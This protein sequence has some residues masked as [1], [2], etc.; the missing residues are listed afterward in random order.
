MV[1]TE[2]QPAVSFLLEIY[3][4]FHS[5]LLNMGMHLSYC[6][7]Q[8]PVT[9]TCLTQCEEEG[10]A[11]TSIFQLFNPPQPFGVGTASHFCTLN[12]YNKT[13]PHLNIRTLS[14]FISYISLVKH[15]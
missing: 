1:S 15:I 12:L 14:I 13:L 5:N 6:I 3:D 9:P 2:V 7:I 10:F 4:S 8:N 11:V